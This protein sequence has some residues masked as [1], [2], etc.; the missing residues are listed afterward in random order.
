MDFLLLNRTKLFATA[1]SVLVS[2]IVVSL[3]SNCAGNTNIKKVTNKPSVNVAPQPQVNL[4]K[5]ADQL[6][7]QANSLPPERAVPI[8]VKASELYILENSADKSLWL[9][10]QTLALTQDNKNQFRLLLVQAQS[11]VALNELERANDKLKHATALLKAKGVSPSFAYFNTLAIIQQQRNLPIAAIDST[12]RAFALNTSANNDDI[13]VIWQQFSQLSTWQHQQLLKLAPPN[14]KGWSQ[15]LDYANRFG[16]DQLRF[17]R[18]LTQWQRNFPTHPAQFIATH[19]QTAPLELAESINNIAV[20][21]PLSGKQ[22]R[23]GKVA[24]QGILSAYKNNPAVNLQFIDSTTVDMTTLAEQF[25]LLEVDYVIGPLLR[26]N[27]ERY[28]QQEELL[29]PTLLLNLPANT[30]LK[31][32]QVALSMRPEDEAIQAATTLSSQNY[33][34]P[35]VLSQ[36]DKSSRRIAQTFVKQWQ[37]ISGQQPE[38]VYFN[39]D[40]KMQD[41]LK[42]GLGV[43]LSQARTSDLNSRIKHSI[44]S[45][46]R[47]RR[48]I[49]MIYIVG[50]PLETK[51]LKP[52]IDVNISP[53]ADI[54]P[55]FASSRS[56]S[57]TSD[58]S[59]NRDLA[60]LVFSEMP[61]Q[62]P[63]KQQNKALAQLSKSLWPSRTDSLQTIFAMGFDSMALV[64]KI[65]IMKHKTYVRHYGQTGVL[66]L[67]QDNILRRSLIWGRYSRN[68]VQ[69][70]VLE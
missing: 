35:I 43:D 29:V 62:L 8:L 48:D 64:D 58:A 67:G 59:D 27:V 36:A 7:T 22:A 34:L 20:I 53:F 14:I 51:L 17:Q 40:E 33:Q 57:S 10:S 69:E 3:L 66:Q 1:K 46:L 54:I 49:D 2:A 13:A 19:L 9:A 16:A 45:E 24:Q 39:S 15:L 26:N 61:W 4:A 65:F 50:S 18:Y 70:I 63:S 38:T 37:H 12:L 11:L 42:S 30:S 56:H 31:S 23:A 6:I 52:Y 55:V 32:H 47:N 5:T 68:S 28:L 21:L 44:K 25:T 60:G 41:Q